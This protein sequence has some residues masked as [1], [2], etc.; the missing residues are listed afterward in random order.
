MPRADG[1]RDPGPCERRCDGDRITELVPAQEWLAKQDK[2]SILY[3]PDAVSPPRLPRHLQRD[4]LKDNLRDNSE[5][6]PANPG[7]TQYVRVTRRINI[8]RYQ[9]DKLF[10]ERKRLQALSL[11]AEKKEQAE[12]NELLELRSLGL[13]TAM[14]AVQFERDEN[15]GGRAHT[16]GKTDKKTASSLFFM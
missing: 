3:D 5:M 1:R 7:F 14:K 4:H 8:D 15:D 2:N 12:K 6:D 13:R 16:H 9:E 11:E 10:Q